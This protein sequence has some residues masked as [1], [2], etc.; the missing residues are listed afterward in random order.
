LGAVYRGEEEPSESLVSIPYPA[1]V[2]DA[3][4]Y[5]SSRESILLQGQPCSAEANH[6]GLA[7]EDPKYI[8]HRYNTWRIIYN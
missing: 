2:I 1:M 4:D 8:E 7:R 5:W 6:S 3:H